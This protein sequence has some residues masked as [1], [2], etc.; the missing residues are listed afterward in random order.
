MTIERKGQYLL[1]NYFQ[2]LFFFQRT[3]S[4]CILYCILLLFLFIIFVYIKV[5]NRKIVEIY[6]IE[7]IL[8][9]KTLLN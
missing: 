7:V 6:R 2:I 5:K 1:E 8:K 3:M 9:P 4:N